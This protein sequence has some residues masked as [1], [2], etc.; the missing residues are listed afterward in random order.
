MDSSLFR[1]ATYLDLAVGNL[2]RALLIG[3]VLMLV[4]LFAFFSNWRTALISAVAIL[5]SAMAAGTLLYLRGVTINM[6]II[7]APLIA[8]GAVIDDA[9]VDTANIVRRLRQHRQVRR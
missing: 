4:A 5:M 8:L 7:A 1:P 6:M 9:I 2:S 3:S